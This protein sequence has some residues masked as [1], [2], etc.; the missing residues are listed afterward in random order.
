MTRFIFTLL[1]LLCIS[2]PLLH[3]NLNKVSEHSSA[4][5]QKTI[6]AGFFQDAWNTIKDLFD[7][8]GNVNG[9]PGDPYKINLGAGS[10][11]GSW[12][13]KNHPFTIFNKHNSESL[14]TTINNIQS[15]VTNSNN[16]SKFDK[17][18]TQPYQE[19]YKTAKA[20]LVNGCGK[21]KTGTCKN[22]HIA[23]NEAFVFLMNFDE[24]G[25][26]LT[27]IKKMIF[28]YFLFL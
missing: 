19:I 6:K 22:A 23:K 25:Q 12:S 10:H 3:Q 8:D 17:Y 15:K 26:S 24:T 28:Y 16:N 9:T 27:L 14:N 11:G 2:V 21:K 18:Y 20:S 7:G 13:D 1:V 5:H 4:S